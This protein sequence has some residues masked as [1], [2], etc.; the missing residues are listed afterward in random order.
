[1]TASSQVASPTATSAHSSIRLDIQ[2]LR[3]LAVGAVLLYHLWPARLP[4]GFVGVDVFFVVSGF[5]ITALILKEVERT[6]RVSLTQFWARRMRRLLPASLLVLGVTL[7]LVVAYLPQTQWDN[8]AKHV[9]ASAFYV[10]NWLLA[11]Q[12]VDYLAAD[13]AS[14]AVQHYWSLSVE[15]QFYVVWPIMILAI[16]ALARRRWRTIAVVAIAVVTL[17]S[18]AYSLWSTATAPTSAY[19][20]TPTRAW[21]F[22]AGALAAALPALRWRERPR[23]VLSWTG[24]ALIVAASFILTGATPFPGWAA[25][26]PVVGALAI[27]VARTES[28]LSPMIVGRLRPVQRLGDLSYSV[29]LW[30]WPLIV[31][32]PAVLGRDLRTVDK[33][34]LIA[35]T[36]IL[37]EVTYRGVEQPLRHLPVL[38]RR[39]PWWSLVA[40][41]ALSVAVLAGALMV[42]RT[43]DRAEDAQVQEL[44]QVGELSEPGG[45]YGAAALAE[46]PGCDDAALDGVLVPAPLVAHDDSVKGT[47]M[48][49]QTQAELRVCESG[50]PV[51]DAVETVA[52]IGDS[53][54]THWIPAVR[55]IAA[56]QGW[57]VVEITKGSCPFTTATR[58]AP[59]D[60]AAS[61]DAWNAAA[62]DYVDTHPEISRVFTSGSS[63]NGFVN[64]GPL[65]SVEAGVAGYAETWDALPATVTD[66]YA[67]RD[68]PRP[69]PDVLDCLVSLPSVEAQL[70]ASECSRPRD[71]ALLVDPLATAADEVGGRV[72]AVD[73]S[74]LFCEPEICRPV[75]GHATV[76]RDGHHMTRSYAESLAPYLAKAIGVA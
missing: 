13:G 60:M 5:L 17:A 48:Q 3:A 36:W 46:G 35:L 61:C 55:A 22:G 76:Y 71:E 18:F 26:L 28:R 30:H 70:D 56:E 47:C 10:E 63:Q 4:G 73:L 24:V 15:E 27:L 8:S 38:A 40:G 31:V 11:A 53:H 12:S 50:V 20:I 49:G 39:S 72:H 32:A 21:E 68:V 75:V 45:C 25:N 62:S 59:A 64:E 54:A 29:Y 67:V 65:T 74:D 66:V 7:V 52:V 43:V 23:A 69:L 19:F 16:A 42:I 51:D 33:V 57:H 37:A 58:A 2:A 44:A 1:M 6:G 41:T 9:I 34:V 14:T